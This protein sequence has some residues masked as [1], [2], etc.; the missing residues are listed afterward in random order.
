MKRCP[1]CG[2][3]KPELEFHKNQSY[4][5]KCQIEYFG[6]YRKKPEQRIKYNTFMKNYYR[7][8]KREL[9]NFMGG[10]CMMCGLTLDDVGDCLGVFEIDEI[11]PLKEISRARRFAGGLNKKRLKQAKQLFRDGKIQLLCAN[12]SRI[13]SS[14]NND[15]GLNRGKLN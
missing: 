2:E 1:R 8:R 7:A 11:E 12:C 9:I 14:K 10:K 4:C 6:E 15:Y 13:K 3:E 5:K